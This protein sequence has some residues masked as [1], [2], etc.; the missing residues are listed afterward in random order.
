M[1]YS[2][3]TIVYLNGEFFL[4]K[5]A[6]IPATDRGFLFGDGVFRTI[7]IQ[8]GHPQFWPQHLQKLKHDCEILGIIP[9][10]ISSEIIQE[11]IDKNLAH[12]GTW[13]LTSRATSKEGL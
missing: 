3:D 11:L 2:K 4:E 12:K 13:R 5:N 7:K 9:P 6:L 1:Y 10:K 8:E